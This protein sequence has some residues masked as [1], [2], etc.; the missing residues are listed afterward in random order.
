MPTLLKCFAVRRRDGDS[1][2]YLYLKL[3]D[4]CVNPVWQAA[5]TL[6]FLASNRDLVEVYQ[7]RLAPQFS[8]Y[9]VKVLDLEVCEEES[10]DNC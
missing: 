3:Q 7:K 8:E 1:Y 10:L 6:D 4:P 5:L 9:A 2:L